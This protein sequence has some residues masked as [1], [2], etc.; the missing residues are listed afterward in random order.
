MIKMQ[1]FNALQ[2]FS[3]HFSVHHSMRQLIPDAESITEFFG[4]YEARGY[5]VELIS[6][7]HLGGYA[8]RMPLGPN[9]EVTPVFPLPASKMQT[10]EDAQRW[11]EHLRDHQI[12]QFAFLLQ[13]R[14]A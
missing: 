12:S 14:L 6:A 7:P 8:L 4:E 2:Y 3:S 11:M 9:D 1:I 13:R 5:R 10:P